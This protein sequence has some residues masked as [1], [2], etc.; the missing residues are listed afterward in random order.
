MPKLTFPRRRYLFATRNGN[1][2]EESSTKEQMPKHSRQF[3]ETL[4]TYHISLQFG[5][6]CTGV[7]GKWTGRIAE[8]GMD[9]H[10]LGRWSHVTITGKNGRKVLITTV[11]QACKASIAAVGAKTAYA[12]QW[13]LL[14]QKGDPQPD[15]RKRFHQDLDEF[16]APYMEAG[17]E[18]L[19]LGDFQ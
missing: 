6:T 19:I 16:L 17:T 1:R 18:I 10:R 13:H 8:Q 11:Y 3:L 2:L 4:P 15:P 7:T 5:G 9:S 12:Q 14:R